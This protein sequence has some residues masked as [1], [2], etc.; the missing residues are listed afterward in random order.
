MVAS[1]ATS[2]S[3]L[4]QGGT[5]ARTA[6]AAG[7]SRPA[8]SFAE[9]LEDQERRP[10]KAEREGRIARSRQPR[11]GGAEAMAAPM[12]AARP[13]AAGGQPAAETVAGSEEQAAK[14]AAAERDAAPGA[15]E[16]KV[17]EEPQ[18]DAAAAQPQPVPA[19]PVPVQPAL[20]ATP[21]TASLPEETGTEDAEAGVDPDGQRMTGTAAEAHAPPGAAAMPSAPAP[22][23]AAGQPAI[24]A[25]SPAASAASAPAAADSAP[26][27]A[28]AAA[29]APA[30]AGPARPAGQQVQTAEMEAASPEG[31]EVRAGEPER[32]AGEAEK[33][34]SR[35]PEA[36]SP[37]AA[38]P[39][40]AEAQAAPT[41][42]GQTPPAPAAGPQ[43]VSA[44]VAQKVA[45]QTPSAGPTVPVHALAVTIAARAASGVTR[46]D[47]RLDPPELGRIDV[48][49]TVD[50][51]GHVRSRLVVEKQ[52][53]LDLLQRDQRSLERALSQAGLRTGEESV[54]FS[55]K[56]QG[57]QQ[58][59][60]ERPEPAPRVLKV[61][62]E[63]PEGL[64]VPQ[65]HL[66]IYARAAA[67]RGGIDIRI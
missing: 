56:D 7:A 61:A 57:G 47:I 55:L 24:A 10:D 15:D 58:P 63:E 26:A 49:L 27:A 17:R 6:S 42:T 39:A 5:V 35:P 46:F 37:A 50:R 31:R 52:E 8:S 9:A 13:Q 33:A 23:E 16:N 21:S 34:A 36:A 41:E 51:E 1:S 19:Q 59:G 22:A 44:E 11:S 3:P 25:A 48:Q 38:S 18:A 29:E 64:Q 28:A 2:V 20:A 40:A 67:M 12:D 45:A 62:V 53:T 4:R 66:A 60:G 30:A 54:E 43:S 32:I 65:A 14:A